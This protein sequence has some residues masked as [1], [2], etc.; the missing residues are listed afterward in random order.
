MRN[1]P[2]D[3]LRTLAL[4]LGSLAG[5]ALIEMAPAAAADQIYSFTDDQGV[6]HLSNVPADPRYQPAA[7]RPETGQALPQRSAE[8][9]PTPELV[10]EP[11]PLAPPPG[12]RFTP[13]TITPTPPE[14]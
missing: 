6:M 9:D 5:A 10:S 7:T 14:R 3:R 11:E 1:D 13:I 12:E 4:W 2:I 8:A